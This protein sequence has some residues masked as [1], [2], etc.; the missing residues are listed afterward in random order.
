MS[1]YDVRKITPVKY[2]KFVY[3][4]ELRHVL[5]SDIADDTSRDQICNAGLSAQVRTLKF[6]QENL[7]VFLPSTL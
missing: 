5:T 1:F 7:S 4:M 6:H 3:I 2:F